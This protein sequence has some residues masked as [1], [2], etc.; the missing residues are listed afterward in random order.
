MNKEVENITF[1]L[2]LG[3]ATGDALGVPFEFLPAQVLRS[4]SFDSLSGYGSH[5]QPPG[6][7]SD[8][9]SLTFCLVEALIQQLDAEKT[10]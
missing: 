6:T 4:V 8:D 2:L 10:A 3:V 9:S 5:N 7:F 1:A